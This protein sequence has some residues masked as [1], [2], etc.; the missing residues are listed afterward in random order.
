[1][2]FLFLA[3]MAVLLLPVV[4]LAQNG[5]VGSVVVSFEYVDGPPSRREGLTFN[6]GTD[7]LLEFLKSNRDGVC[8]IGDEKQVMLE[9][10]VSGD[11]VQITNQ[12]KT[13]TTTRASVL[14]NF[15][16]ARAAGHLA[17][18]QVNI[19][20]IAKALRAWAT[21]HSGQYPDSLTQLA[22]AYLTSVPSCTDRPDLDTYG[23]SYRKRDS[24]FVLQCSVDHSAA[25]VPKGV[26]A[27]DS[28]FGLIKTG[29]ELQEKFRP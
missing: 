12:G 11:E 24:H 18:C 22:P 4:S 28:D 2:R 6:E 3:L 19:Q 25:E 29:A 8:R 21:D 16:S 13:Q 1:M 17:A 27:Y 5:S 26:P 9:M 10:R 7:A 15:E 20:Q 14:A 23:S